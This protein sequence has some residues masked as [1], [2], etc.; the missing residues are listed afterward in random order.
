MW[1]FLS[2]SFLSIVKIRSLPK[3]RLLV[4]A[5]RRGDISRV[6]P[7]VRIL[8]T[9]NRDYAWR[10]VVSQKAVAAALTNQVMAIDYSNF[11][12]SVGIRDY[13]RHAAYLRVWSAMEEFQLPRRPSLLF[14]SGGPGRPW[15]QELALR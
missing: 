5:R 8:K 4:R 15:R 9:P 7:K 6:F 11:K 10:A 3:G 14:K 12:D 1:V 13:A 2:N